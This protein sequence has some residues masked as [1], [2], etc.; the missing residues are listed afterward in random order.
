MGTCDNNLCSVASNLSGLA[1][2]TA[3]DATFRTAF[4]CPNF[5]FSVEPGGGG[6]RQI[7]D[8]GF[9]CDVATVDEDPRRPCELSDWA[10]K[11][12]SETLRLRGADILQFAAGTS[13]G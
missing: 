7:D 4:G 9:C 11:R 1:V 2:A 12:S 3:D 8:A 10:D 13:C 5:D 6:G